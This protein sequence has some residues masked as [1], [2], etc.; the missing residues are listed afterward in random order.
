[1]LNGLAQVI[2]TGWPVG[3]REMPTNLHQFWSYRDELAVED[4]IIFKGQQ[5]PIP[6]LLR[7]DILAQL[8]S[9][10]QGIEKTRHMA[11]ESVYWPRMNKDIED[12]CKRCQLCQELQ[13]QKQREPM[14]MHEK[15]GWPWVKFGTGLFEIGQRNFLMTSDYFSRYPIIKELKSITSAAVVT[16]TTGILS[17]LG[18]PREIVSDNGPQYQGIY[19]QFCAE[20]GIQHTIT[21]PKILTI[22]WIHRTPN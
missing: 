20:W 7:P 11:R 2:F 10:H 16:A 3:I 13:P 22:K 5:V 15:P 17:M 4:G 9:G 21:S 14:K 18:V 6:R 1:M 12:L 19:N 8:H